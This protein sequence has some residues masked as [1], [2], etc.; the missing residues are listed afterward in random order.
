MA[1]RFPEMEKQ[2]R[3][4]ETREE[5]ERVERY[6]SVGAGDAS[7]SSVSSRSHLTEKEQLLAS[8]AFNTQA[9]EER[10]SAIP[11]GAAAAYSTIPK[12]SNDYSSAPAQGDAYTSV[13]QGK[14]HSTT[15]QS[16]YEALDQSTRTANSSATAGGG[17]SATASHYAPLD[18]STRTESHYMSSTSGRYDSV[19]NRELEYSSLS[20]ATREAPQSYQKVFRA[21]GEG[22]ST[23]GDYDTTL[24]KAEDDTTLYDSTLRTVDES[25][26][27]GYYD[28]T[29][30]KAGGDEKP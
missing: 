15:G 1:R 27:G 10:Y 12:E 4:S 28:S 9:G 24:M 17:A 7:S 6:G 3:I 30:F 2:R 29:L 26:G 25:G 20:H 22:G 16:T 18:Q 8:T 19:H 5:Y 11:E 14:K 13:T 23:E 21:A